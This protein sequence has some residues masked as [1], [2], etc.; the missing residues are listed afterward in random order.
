MATIIRLKIGSV[1]V[2]E[3]SLESLVQAFMFSLRGSSGSRACVLSCHVS[4]GLTAPAQS[5]PRQDA[6]PGV[7]MS[8]SDMQVV[9]PT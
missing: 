7:P 8:V 4:G 5:P 2:G 3:T 6:Q 1:R 9:K